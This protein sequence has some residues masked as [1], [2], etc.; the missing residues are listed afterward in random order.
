MMLSFKFD[1]EGSSYEDLERKA[2]WK[3]K[4]FFGHARFECDA[5]V[6]EAPNLKDW[7][8]ATVTAS[9]TG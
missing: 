5:Y 8:Q 1:I 4:E 7:Y 3:A 2:F 9:E 6:I